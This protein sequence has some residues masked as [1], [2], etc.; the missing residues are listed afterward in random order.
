[1]TTQEILIQAKE[2]KTAL[3]L[4]DAGRRNTAL[5][6]MADALVKPE[7]MARIL[8]ANRRDL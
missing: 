2:S 3:M 6:K 5:L 4:A 1:M 7:H 8:E